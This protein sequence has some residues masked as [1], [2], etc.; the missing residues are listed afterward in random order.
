MDADADKHQALIR[1]YEL[2]LNRAPTED[3]IQWC[4]QVVK[5]EGLDIVCRALL[6]SNEFA[7]LQ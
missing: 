5:D 7:F 4:Q 1:C 2:I 3:E 6:N